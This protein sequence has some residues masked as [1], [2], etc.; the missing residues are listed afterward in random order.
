M[1]PAGDW[2]TESWTADGKISDLMREFEGWDGRVQQ[3]IASATETKRWA[4]TRGSPI[5]ILCGR[6]LGCMDTMPNRVG[7]LAG[8][9]SKIPKM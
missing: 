2:R 5:V 9:V 3:L 8:K 1:A 6:V 4:L 7:P